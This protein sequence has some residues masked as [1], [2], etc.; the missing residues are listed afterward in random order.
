MTMMM[1]AQIS[2]VLERR[3]NY[4]IK[5]I[6]SPFTLTFASITKVTLTQ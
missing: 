5:T 6:T 2:F 4:D 1:M 3:F